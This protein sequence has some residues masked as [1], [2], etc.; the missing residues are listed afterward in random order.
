[1]RIDKATV[2]LAAA[3]AEAIERAIAAAAAGDPARAGQLLDERLAA[4]SEEERGKWL[5]QL[6]R[7]APLLAAHRVFEM[8]GGLHGADMWQLSGDLGD[9]H[10]AELAVAQAV[11]AYL[12]EDYG[13]G[14]DVIAAQYALGGGDALAEMITRAIRFCVTVSRSNA[15]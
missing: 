5:H 7:I 8:K 9:L 4:A 2:A 1:M 13:A 15:G 14:N 12:N 10:P 3:H 6:A 11:T